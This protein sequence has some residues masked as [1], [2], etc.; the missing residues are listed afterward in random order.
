MYECFFAGLKVWMT[1]S[2]IFLD[3]LDFCDL[4]NF[5]LRINKPR[6]RYFVLSLE[7]INFLF[8][9]K[10]GSVT[11]WHLNNDKTKGAKKK[12]D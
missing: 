9:F 4:G 8:A 2:M 7:R 12:T 5:D 10:N 6:D 11:K 3:M 1:G